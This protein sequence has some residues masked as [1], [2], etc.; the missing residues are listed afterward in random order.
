MGT[1]INKNGVTRVLE[2]GKIGYGIG[3][4]VR[5]SG[6]SY[7]QKIER[8]F[9]HPEYVNFVMKDMGLS[10]GETVQIQNPAK[11]G[12]AIVDCGPFGKRANENIYLENV[13]IVSGDANGCYNYVAT[14]D[15]SKNS[16][17][18]QKKARR[19]HESATYM[20]RKSASGYKLEML[21]DNLEWLDAEK[22]EN[23]MMR[24]A[25][26]HGFNSGSS[27]EIRSCKIRTEKFSL[28]LKIARVKK[29]KSFKGEEMMFVVSLNSGK[30]WLLPAE[31]V[32]LVELGEDV[33]RKKCIM[34]QF[35][36]LRQVGASGNFYISE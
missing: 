25:K 6:E 15:Q 18:Y 35:V 23:A 16:G 33:S 11:R 8:F 3:S 14:L 28:D 17:Q 13:L 31:Q 2:T 34:T 10:D 7:E 4:S 20:V 26:M 22:S 36:W 21:L 5:S 32:E 19:V 1:I 24:L 29:V 12:E 30:I 9:K 27:T